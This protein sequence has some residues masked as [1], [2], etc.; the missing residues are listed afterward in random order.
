[1]IPI[2]SS[3]IAPLPLSKPEEI[4]MNATIAIA[5]GMMYLTSVYHR[6]NSGKDT[7]PSLVISF[8]RSARF[9][10]FVLFV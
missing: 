5:T 1:M 9:Q 8:S 6:P 4:P 3:M 7:S 2:P 10:I